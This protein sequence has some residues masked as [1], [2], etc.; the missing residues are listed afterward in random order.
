MN[1][2]GWLTRHA[3]TVGGDGQSAAS[4]QPQEKSVQE[5][6]AQEKSA[7]EKSVQEESGRVEAA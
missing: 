1:K 6:S 7:Q 5:T 4:L 2:Q 3:D